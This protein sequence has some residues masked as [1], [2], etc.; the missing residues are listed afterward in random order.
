MIIIKAQLTDAC[1][2]V[3]TQLVAFIAS[4]L[5]RTVSIDTLV[6]TNASLLTLVSVHT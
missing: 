2:S 5:I 3:R 4:A 6:V 1:A